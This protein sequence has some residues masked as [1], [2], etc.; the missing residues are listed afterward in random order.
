MF[1]KPNLGFQNSGGKEAVAMS[2][3]AAKDLTQRELEVMHVFW[4]RGPLTAAQARAHLATAGR[5]LTYTT[6]ATLVRILHD[7]GFLKQ[8]NQERPFVYAPARSYEEVSKRLL[9]DV[10][11]RVFKGSREQLL[12]RLLEQRQLTGQERAFLQALLEEDPA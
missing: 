4:K 9:G 12:V 7:K 10:L 5:D 1:G 3:P 8:M 2:R 6:V 11:D